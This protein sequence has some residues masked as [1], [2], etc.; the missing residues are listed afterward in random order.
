[1]NWSFLFC[2]CSKF[3]GFPPTTY[4][5]VATTYYNVATTWSNALQR[6]NNVLQRGNNL[7]QCTTTWQQRDT[8]WL[9]RIKNVTKREQ[10][11]CTMLRYVSATLCSGKTRCG[12][13]YFVTAK[14]HGPILIFG[15]T[16][17]SCL[18]GTTKRRQRS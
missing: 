13:M 1:M 16:C 17:Q 10:N 15:V 2:T 8:T 4:Y 5:N 11:A 12:M 3:T 14:R 6:G 18:G 7:E 9:Q